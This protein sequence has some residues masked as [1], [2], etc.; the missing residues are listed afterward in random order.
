[1]RISDW[2][3]DVCSSDLPIVRS[4][5]C[6]NELPVHSQSRFLWLSIC[7]NVL[8]HILMR[9]G[10]EGGSRQDRRPIRDRGGFSYVRHGERRC[11]AAQRLPVDPAWHN[12][13]RPDPCAQK[14]SKQPSTEKQRGG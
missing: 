13:W 9:G 8:Y 4:D 7:D 14:A 12:R 11:D 6:T 5:R 3:S 2:S 10:H 1:M